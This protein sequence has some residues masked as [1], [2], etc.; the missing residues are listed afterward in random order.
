MNLKTSVAG[1][2]IICIHIERFAISESLL[3][4]S[5]FH[6]LVTSHVYF[7]N[8]QNECSTGTGKT[9]LFIVPEA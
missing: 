2:W 1:N 8:K 9:G 5:E 4:Q 6:N 3:S 7:I